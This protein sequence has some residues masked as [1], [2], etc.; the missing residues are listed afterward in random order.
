[1]PGFGLR[2]I[3]LPHTTA[4]E[5]PRCV[6]SL[7]RNEL[8][9]ILWELKGQDEP[10]L[11]NISHCQQSPGKDNQPEIRASDLSRKEKR[12]LSLARTSFDKN[13]KIPNITARRPEYQPGHGRRRC[14]YR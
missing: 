6:C 7:S 1:M 12:V 2:Y 3:A 14:E 8:K 11:Y 13:L 10:R 9:L 4:L 5:W